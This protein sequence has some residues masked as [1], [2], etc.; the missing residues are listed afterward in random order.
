MAGNNLRNGTNH[1]AL[2]LAIGARLRRPDA[3]D[4]AA[5]QYRLRPHVE[6]T[7]LE[8]GAAQIGD[9]NLHFRVTTH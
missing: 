1:E 9:E 5:R 3:L 2:G 7:V 8:A 6:E 4:P